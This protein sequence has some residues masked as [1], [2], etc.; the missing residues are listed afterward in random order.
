MVRRYNIGNGRTARVPLELLQQ[1]IAH[2]MPANTASLP[3]GQ[4]RN[5]INRVRRTSNALGVAVPR[6]RA[7]RRIIHRSRVQSYRE[8]TRS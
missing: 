8:R 4:R 1:I 7:N 5:A 2:L 6:T 3:R